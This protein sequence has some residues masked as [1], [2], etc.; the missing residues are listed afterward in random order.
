M[1]LRG[2]H[3]A[4]GEVLRQCDA[5]EIDPLGV[6]RGRRE[7]AILEFD[8]EQTRHAL[9]IAEYLGPRGQI[10]RACDSPTMVKDGSGWGAHVGLT[11]A[12]LAREGF[13]GAPALTVER[14]DA[15]AFWRD[16]GVRWRI[17]EQYFKAYPVCR[18]AQPAIEAALDLK[19]E[20]GFVAGDVTAIAIESFRE[21]WRLGI[22]VRAPRTTEGRSTAWRV[23]VAAALVPILSAPMGSTQ[24]ASA[25]RASRASS[26]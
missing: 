2:H 24:S 9:G 14:D 22:A 6:L 20:H 7:I 12:L 18:W 11:A 25:I 3:Q 4:R 23:P 1:Q 19:R 13:T 15:A 5:R 26:A 8:A 10:L 21:G 16:L 17:G